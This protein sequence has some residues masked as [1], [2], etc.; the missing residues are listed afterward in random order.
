MRLAAAVVGFA[1]FMGFTGAAAIFIFALFPV[2]AP[3]I[4]PAL[5]RMDAALGYDWAGFV[6][7]LAGWPLVGTTLG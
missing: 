7:A 5:I 3:L 2:S 4:D 6:T 1:V